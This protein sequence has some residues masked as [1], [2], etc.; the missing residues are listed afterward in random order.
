MINAAEPVDQVAIA[1][2]YETFR[3]FGL[4]SGV[5]VPTYGLAE[6]TVFVCS[7]GSTILTLKKSSFDS[8]IIEI[9]GSA[10]LGESGGGGASSTAE[11][12]D[13]IQTIVGCG[14]PLRGEGVRVIIVDSETHGM[15]GEDK[16]RNV[17]QLFA[18]IS[19]P[20]NTTAA[21]CI[22]SQKLVNSSAMH[23]LQEEHKFNYLVLPYCR[24]G[25]SGSPQGPRPADTGTCPS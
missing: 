19:A 5:V 22:E 2:F 12:D 18:P 8:K 16:V 23:L 10:V 17:C 1:N 9:V 13:T 21:N 15:L 7:G 11:N 14:F 3:P 24:S 4:S 6:H 25:R 20:L